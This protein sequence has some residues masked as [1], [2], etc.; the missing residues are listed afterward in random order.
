MIRKVILLVEGN[1]EDEGLTR[2]ALAHNR[3]GNEVVTVRNGEEALDWLFCTGRYARRDARDQPAVVLLNLELEG[4]GGLEVL[5]RIRSHADTKAVPVVLLTSSQEPPDRLPPGPEASA[6][7][8]K[9]VTFDAFVEAICRTGLYWVI[10]S[11][12]DRR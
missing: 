12:P 3:V 8:Q 11:D 9:P 7:L 10:A 4:V 1:A 2:G 5:R 6:L